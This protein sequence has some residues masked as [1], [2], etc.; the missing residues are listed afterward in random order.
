MHPSCSRYISFLS[1]LLSGLLFL[2]LISET[3]LRW[4]KCSSA[5]FINWILI[6]KWKRTVFKS[7]SYICSWLILIWWS[8]ITIFIHI[9]W[10]C[11]NIQVMAIRELWFIWLWLC[12]PCNSSVLVWVWDVQNCTWS[13]PY[14]SV[15][16]F[17]AQTPCTAAPLLHSVHQWTW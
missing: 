4:S 6:V 12:M 17:H 16:I 7:L 9:E 3:C 14:Q 2:F 5:E 13:C 1:G 8:G 10:S 15:D 11:E